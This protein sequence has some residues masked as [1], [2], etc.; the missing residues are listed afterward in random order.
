MARSLF[1]ITAAVVYIALFVLVLGLMVFRTHGFEGIL[2]IEQG[3]A[4]HWVVRPHKDGG[5]FSFA[6]RAVPAEL[7]GLDNPRIA[8]KI[9]DGQ[10]S[11]DAEPLPF[12]LHLEKA[13]V[14][15]ERARK[16]I[17]E[18]TLP[19]QRMVLDAEP[20]LSVEVP[21]GQITVASLEPWAGL[22]RHAAGLPMA[23][24]AFQDTEHQWHPPVFA[25]AD[26]S[27]HPLPGVMALLRR[28][29]D[30]AAARAAFPG[31][32]ELDRELRWGIREAGRIHWFTSLAPGTGVT[33][34]DG[35]EYTLVNSQTSSG[36]ETDYILVEKKNGADSTVEKVRANL[37]AK[38]DTILFERHVN[39][40]IFLM[41]A[42]GDG[43]AWIAP[44]I[45]GKK[46]DETLL[47]DGESLTVGLHGEKKLCL[48]MD[49]VIMNAIPVPDFKD[50]VKALVLDTPDGVLRLR[51]GMSRQ[52]KA[53]R[54]A[55]HRQPQAP[56]VRY[57]LRSVFG[58]D[59]PPLEFTLEPQGARRI[60]DW[61]FYHDQDNVHAATLAVLRARHAPGTAGLYVALL[62]FVVST[63]GLLYTRFLARKKAALP[64]DEAE[65]WKQWEPVEEV[66]PPGPGA[67]T[68]PFQGNSG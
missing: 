26:E 30:E 58:G 41:H 55:Y 60:G 9:L 24:F 15:E 34:S 67:D 63:A 44:Y 57:T 38:N 56:L 16:N 27:V 35:M 7:I 12:T 6:Y 54:V 14:L 59:R 22:I 47:K 50:G 32:T 68:G 39:D 36:G 28:F 51:E 37:A 17:L 46:Q 18:V 19:E 40:V 49:Q 5:L 62:L 10:E 52:I 21:E 64:T 33:T 48:R 20:G 23:A 61:R 4:E 42:W 8:L 25:N 13:E 29:P 1:K 3:R 53:S 66:A 31:K 2:V 65:D 11:Y 45:F 43:R